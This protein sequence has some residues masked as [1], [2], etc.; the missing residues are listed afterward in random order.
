MFWKVIIIITGVYLIGKLI[1]RSFVAYLFGETS[2][3]VQERMNRQG[4]SSTRQKKHPDGHV[5]VHYQPD[6]NKSIGKDEGDYVD[7]EEVK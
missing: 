5:S 1:F 4:G 2:K 7:F 3:R 6:S